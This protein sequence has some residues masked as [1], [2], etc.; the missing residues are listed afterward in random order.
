MARVAISGRTR[1]WAGV[2]LSGFLT[3]RML[4]HHCRIAEH[5][6]GPLSRTKTPLSSLWA[7]VLLSPL[8]KGRKWL[9]RTEVTAF[10]I[11][12]AGPLAPFST[13]DM[14]PKGWGYALAKEAFDN[15]DTGPCLMWGMTSTRV[16]YCEYR[17]GRTKEALSEM[18]SLR[19]QM[20]A[21]NAAVARHAPKDSRLFHY[22]RKPPPEGRR[23]RGDSR[24]HRD[25]PR[26]VVPRSWRCHKWT[27]CTRPSMP[28]QCTG[29]HG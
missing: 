28:G 17:D 11:T 1:P 5:I 6:Y 16:R 20:V 22:W 24:E 2:W 7:L 4:R 13:T 9:G 29:T 19:E 3:G 18:L 23:H 12:V 25:C 21:E 14:Y 8:T 26:I 10:S 15:R 27:R